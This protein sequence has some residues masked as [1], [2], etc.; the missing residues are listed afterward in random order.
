VL[1]VVVV[2]LYRLQEAS[3]L[4]GLAAITISRYFIAGRTDLVRGE[5]FFV[6]RAGPC[7][8]QLVITERGLKRLQTRSYRVFREGK[9]ASI[10]APPR[11]G[12]VKLRGDVNSTDRRLRVKASVAQAFRAYLEHP[13]AV[14][15]CQCIIHRLGAP[16]AD[17]LT[18][19]I[20]N[21]VPPASRH[22]V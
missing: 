18:N 4:A 19:Y 3:V 22:S 16:Q 17:E 20:L 1:L 12:I 2:A 6:R 8:R 13:C 14:P 15:G 11:A 9:Q 21:A 5:D 7:R 10:V